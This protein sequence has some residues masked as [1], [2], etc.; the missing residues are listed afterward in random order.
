MILLNLRIINQ[1]LVLLQL[2][3]PLKRKLKQLH[4]KLQLHLNRQLLL[5]RPHLHQLVAEFLRHPW[6]RSS[7]M[8]RAWIFLVFLE[9]VLTIESLNKTLRLPFKLPQLRRPLLLLKLF[10]LILLLLTKIK[11]SQTLERLLQTDCHTPSRTFPITTWLLL[12]VLITC[13]NLDQNLI[14]FQSQRFQLTIWLSKQLH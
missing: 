10:F 13:S 11:M 8:K 5:K 9:A 7:Q 12:S 6:L 14:A 1:L 3:L 4:N 2:P